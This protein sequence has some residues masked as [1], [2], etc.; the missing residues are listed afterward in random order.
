MTEPDLVDENPFDEE[1]WAQLPALLERLPEP[2][3]LVVWGDETTPREAEAVRLCRALSGRFP[4]ITS[5]TLPRRANYDYWPVLGVM[6]GTAEGYEDVGARIIGLP[7]GYQMTSFIAAIQ[8]VSF[9]GMTSEALTRIQLS[10]LQKEVRVELLTAADNEVGAMMAH[11]LFN[12]AAVSPH[13]RVFMIMADQFPVIIER[14][15]VNYLPHTVLNGRVHIEGVVDEKE[16]LQHIVKA[17]N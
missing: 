6:H 8:A 13:V 12:M 9:R 5:Q 10:K 7:N 15:S 1:T 2:V 14:Y 11:P 16:I 3:H 4:I 17:I